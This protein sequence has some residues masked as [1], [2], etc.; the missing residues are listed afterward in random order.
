M[1]ESR[2]PDS[3]I[4]LDG[5]LALKIGHLL[6]I[7]YGG[8]ARVIESQYSLAVCF[9]LNNWSSTK[10]VNVA[11]IGP[12]CCIEANYYSGMF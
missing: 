8:G 2:G 5:H 7:Q 12:L 11:V 3:I 6:P 10:P 4:T 9:R 1:G